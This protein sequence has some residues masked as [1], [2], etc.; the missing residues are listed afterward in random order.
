MIT[1]FNYKKK[2]K[3]GVNQIDRYLVKTFRVNR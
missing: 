2:F 1:I 3:F